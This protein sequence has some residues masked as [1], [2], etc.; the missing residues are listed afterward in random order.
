[1]MEC[2]MRL[3][4]TPESLKEKLGGDIEDSQIADLILEYNIHD[5]KIRDIFKEYIGKERLGMIVD[6]FIK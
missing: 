5:E 2:L 6:K 1:M 3:L 4:N